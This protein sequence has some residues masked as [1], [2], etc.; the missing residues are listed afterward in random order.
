LK[1]KKTVTKLN[2][3]IAVEK[4]VKTN[5]EN[6]FTKTLRIAEKADLFAG[7]TK[8]YEPLVEDDVVLPGEKKLVQARVGDLLN[9]VQDLLVRQFDLTA[10]KDTANGS[11]AADIVVN[12]QVIATMVPVTTLLWIEKKLVD[13]KTFISRLPILDPAESWTYNT[14][15]GY[16]QSSPL[17]TMR[18]IKKPVFLTVAAATDK[19][20]AQVVRETEDVFTGKWTTTKLSG[21]IPVTR[22]DA[23]LA[24]VNELAEA[25]KRA[26][27]EA[28]SMTVTDVNIGANILSY[29]FR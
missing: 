7:L 20:Q 15:T 2:Q 12:G 18:Q 22:R 16:W 29:L 9:D 27:E 5:T 24:Q 26:R 21:A 10:T 23:L 1:G 13:V 19:H 11:A 25:V 14:G 3:I 17:E 4:T 8:V 28:N 6:A